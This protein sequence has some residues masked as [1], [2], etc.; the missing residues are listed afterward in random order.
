MELIGYTIKEDEKGIA[1]KRSDG[2]SLTTNHL[3]QAFDFRLDII[4]LFNIERLFEIH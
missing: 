1:I 4:Q 3:F 2:A